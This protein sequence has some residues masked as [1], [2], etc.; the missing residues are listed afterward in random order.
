M[1]G[2]FWEADLGILEKMQ[3]LHVMATVRLSHAYEVADVDET[4]VGVGQVES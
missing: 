1:R 4:L 3:R 2:A